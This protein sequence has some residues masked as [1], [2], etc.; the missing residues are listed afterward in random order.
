MKK[1][2]VLLFFVLLFILA[3]GLQGC[4]NTRLHD[5]STTTTETEK[6][7]QNSVKNYQFH[8]AAISDEF[9]FA[10]A[11]IKTGSPDKNCD[12]LCNAQIQEMLEKINISKQSGNNS[13]QWAY[14]SLNNQIV[15]TTQMG[16]TIN[17]YR[18]SVAYY[19]DLKAQK[20]EVVKEVPVPRQLSKWEAFFIKSGQIL[21]V[22][23]LVYLALKIAKIYLSKYNFLS[24]INKS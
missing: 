7:K 16:E 12:S 1:N 5:K 3:L 21:W 11:P 2:N 22:V 17:Q 6:E 4:G 13:Y 23:V 8:S 9:K 18:D 14:D 20:I 10:L 19:K 15:I 24:S